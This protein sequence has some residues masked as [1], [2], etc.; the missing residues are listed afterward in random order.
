MHRDD[1]L[2]GICIQ[3]RILVITT[4]NEAQEWVGRVQVL[5]V[6]EDEEGSQ[7]QRMGQNK[8]SR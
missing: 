7:T 6:K 4:L 1:V 8:P 3:V 2:V 5:R